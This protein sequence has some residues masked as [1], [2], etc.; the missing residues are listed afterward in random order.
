MANPFLLYIG[1]GYGKNLIHVCAC[2]FLF[3]PVFNQFFE[4][5][6]NYSFVL[7]HRISN[8]EKAQSTGKHYFIARCNLLP[9]LKLHRA[10]TSDEPHQKRSPH[11]MIYLDYSMIRNFFKDIMNIAFLWD[12]EE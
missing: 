11:R 2:A 12:D 1:L 6:Y 4:I 3:M 7:V 8:D 9:D 5:H 10:V